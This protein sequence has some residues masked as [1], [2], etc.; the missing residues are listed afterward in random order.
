MNNEQMLDIVANNLANASTD[1]YK[2]DRVSFQDTLTQTLYSNG[3]QG[4]LLGSVGMGPAPAQESTDF[5]LGNMRQTGNTL[6]L[7]LPNPNAMLTV[8]RG[9]Q[10]LYTRSGSLT[11]DGGRNL[12]T[13]EGDAV[14]DNR[15]NRIEIPPGT[16]QIG[17]DGT[18]SVTDPSAGNASQTVAQL[19]IVTGNFTKA[20][21]NLYSGNRV[22]SDANP[23]VT[24]GTLEGSNVNSIS[25][26]V[27]LIRIGRLYDL[28]QK[29]ATSED[30]MSSKLLD[31]LN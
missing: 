21:N 27:D 9:N 3:G 12:V 22:Q 10:I 13:Q 30:Q 11:L 7:A 19:G 20:G 1:G 8:Q 29:S 2:A 26:M 25:A 28:Q 23:R 5:Q 4:E 14:L 31:A 18:V 24:S 15:G 16:I 17:A 6:D